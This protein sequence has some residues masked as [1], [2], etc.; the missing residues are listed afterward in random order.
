MPATRRSL[1][2]LFTDLGAAS[3]AH[4]FGG[5]IMDS[6]CAL[7]NGILLEVFFLGIKADNKFI[8]NIFGAALV[9]IAALAFKIVFPTVHVE[10]IIIGSI[11]PLVPGIALTTS[12]R[13]LFHSD[14]LSG[15]IHLLDALLTAVSIAVGV[16]SIITLVKIVG[17][18]I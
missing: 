16:G 15:A 1:M 17:G 18:Q 3:F 11:M 2:I 5:T 8:K 7:I 14:C 9:T 12:I 13:D 6:L 10:R 4:I